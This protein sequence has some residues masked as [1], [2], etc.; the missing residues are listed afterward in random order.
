MKM[1]IG[2]KLVDASDG[3]TYNNINPATGEVIETVPY[4][5]AQD[6]ETAISNAVEGQKEWAAMPFHKR[7]EILEKFVQLAEQNTGQ[8]QGKTGTHLIHLFHKGKYG[9]QSSHG[10]H[11]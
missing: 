1:L 3:K 9:E 7:M 2:G 8:P 4:A 11:I 5:T 6:V 10:A